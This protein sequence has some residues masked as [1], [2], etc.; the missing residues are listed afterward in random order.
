MGEDFIRVIH[1]MNLFR[2]YVCEKILGAFV[3]YV[4]RSGLKIPH[5]HI[6]SSK[7]TSFRVDPRDDEDLFI[8]L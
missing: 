6:K 1:V 3:N 5:S 8:F 2:R 7:S 4:A